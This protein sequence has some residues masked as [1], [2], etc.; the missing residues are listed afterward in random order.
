MWNHELVGGTTE[1]ECLMKASMAQGKQVLDLLSSATQ[2]EVQNLIQNGDLVKRMMQADLSK[3][4]RQAFAAFLTPPPRTE[5]DLFVPVGAAFHRF[6][7]RARVREWFSEVEIMQLHEELTERNLWD[8]ESTLAGA[9][10]FDI[11]LG[12]LQRTIDELVLW[13]KDVNLGFSH[14][15]DFYSDDKHLRL[16]DMVANKYGKTSSVKPTNIDLLANQGKAPRAARAN[17]LAGLEILA[18]IAMHPVFPLHNSRETEI[19]FWL[20]SLEMTVR[21]RNPWECLP[22]LYWDK[23]SHNVCLGAAWDD[24]G[25]QDCTVPVSRKL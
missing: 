13:A 22:I 6:A 14:W 18:A 21:G 4:D 1:K 2:E 11:W 16:L 15:P 17:N 20:G 12:D 7:E 3:V 25:D 19:S 10:S 23:A 5:S 9:F 24:N 8:F